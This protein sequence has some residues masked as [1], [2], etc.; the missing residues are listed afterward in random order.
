MI[1]FV[2]NVNA[3]ITSLSWI[4]NGCY[5]YKKALQKDSL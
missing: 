3:A 4:Y 1:A 5:Y 2:K